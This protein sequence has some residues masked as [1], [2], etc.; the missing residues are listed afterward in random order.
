MTIL[1]IKEE[2]NK[3]CTLYKYY[4][5]LFKKSAFTCKY[6]DDGQI[7]IHNGII[8]T[9]GQSWEDGRS[10]HSGKTKGLL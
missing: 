5:L 2:Q 9:K 10:E 4:L 1:T 7:E 3:T 6:I 8:I